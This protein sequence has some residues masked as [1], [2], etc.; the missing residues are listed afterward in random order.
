M[1]RATTGQEPFAFFELLMHLT[2]QMCHHRLQEPTPLRSSGCVF[3]PF[4]Q[5][6]DS[7]DWWHGAHSNMQQQQ[8]YDSQVY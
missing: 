6:R 1:Q 4:L 2:L 7:A 5:S 8:K 3:W